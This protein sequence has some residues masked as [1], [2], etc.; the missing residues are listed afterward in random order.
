VNIGW[1]QPEQLLGLHCGRRHRGLAGGPPRCGG[2]ACL[3]SR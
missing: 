3:P 1:P 2:A